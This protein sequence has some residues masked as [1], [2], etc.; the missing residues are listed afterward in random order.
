MPD[1]IVNKGTALHNLIS[2]YTT[3]TSKHAKGVTGMGATDGAGK[4]GPAANEK[5]EKRRGLEA[6]ER[7]A[8]LHGA[9]TGRDNVLGFVKKV[10]LH[11]GW[12][13]VLNLCQTCNHA[14]TKTH[15]TPHPQTEGERQPPRRGRKALH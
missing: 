13:G 5:A 11:G 10:C 4:R 15:H 3:Y 7:A 6:L 8:N 14:R 12:E 9:P 1:L 2:A